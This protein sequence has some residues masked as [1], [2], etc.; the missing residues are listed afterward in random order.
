MFIIRKAEKAQTKMR[1]GLAGVS[2]S[3]KTYSALLLASGLTTWEKICV[4]DTENRSA[5]LYSTLGAYNVITLAAPYSPERYIEAITA[6]EQSGMEVII[7]DSITHE[8]DGVGGCLDIQDKLGGKFQDWAKVTPRHNAFVQKILTS[9]AHIITTVRKKQDYAMVNE[10]GKSR[11]EKQ[12]LKEITREGFEYELTATFTLNLNH[13]AE[14]SKDRTGLF[15]GKPPF[16]ISAETGSTIK[17]WCNKGTDQVKPTEIAGKRAEKFL[18]EAIKIKAD[19]VGL[20]LAKALEHFKVADIEHLTD[21]QANGLM[22]RLKKIEEEKEMEIARKMAED[23]SKL[24]K[25]DLD[26]EF[27]ELV[28]KSEDIKS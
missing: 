12:G 21:V 23:R 16:I 15:M 28:K 18:I 10:G 24:E 14:V 7:I 25:V 3:G 20:N 5:D 13:L 19:K 6:C 2:G 27:D 8:W 4:I 11:V 22:I 9:T 26:A 1:L 17:E